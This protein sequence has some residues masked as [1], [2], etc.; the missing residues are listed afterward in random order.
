MPDP[1]QGCGG[2]DTTAF[3]VDEAGGIS[4][5]YDPITGCWSASV[6]VDPSSP[7]PLTLT[8]G[9]SAN[10]SV[11]DTTSIDH[12]LT[13]GNLQSAVKNSP[14]AYNGLST[15][16]NGQYAWPGIK[17]VTFATRP[18][19]PFIGQKIW[20]TDTFKAMQWVG[21]I[22]GWQPLDWNAPWGQVGRSVN[23]TTPQ[24]G[25][26][27]RFDLPNMTCTFNA[28]TNRR[29]KA[30]LIGQIYHA[31]A[32]TY[33]SMWLVANAVDI[34]QAF[35][36]EALAGQ[37]FDVSL[38]QEFTVATGSRIV[39]AAMANGNSTNVTFQATASSPGYL[40]VEDVGPSGNPS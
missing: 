23:V 22:M 4:W 11:T 12:T 13:A 32:I 28:L 39:K 26:T 10:F 19:T 37:Q 1:C 35:F 25:I 20:E 29:Y 36:V 5:T 33:S 8:N 14:D 30:R 9:L 15:L 34:R 6:D 38:E 27:T 17:V 40:Y 18:P 31:T 24:A 2:S 3:C 7:I 16:A 21:P